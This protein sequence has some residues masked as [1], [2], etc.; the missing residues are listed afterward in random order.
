MRKLQFWFAVVIVAVLV[1]SPVH[2]L[3]QFWLT[4]DPAG[5]AAS[6]QAISVAP[7]KPVTLYCF[8]STDTTGNTFETM[9]G[10]DVSDATTYGSGKDT[11]NGASKKLTL[12][13][14]QAAIASSID[15]TFFNAFPAAGFTN[16]QVVLDASGVQASNA[17][18]GG[19]PYG[20]IARGA[21]TGAITY[22]LS[23]KLFSFAL[24]NNMPD[25]Q[26]QN[27]VVS[28]TYAGSN[29]YSSAWKYGTTM[30]ENEYTLT[31]NSVTSKPVI[32]ASNRSAASKVAGTAQA[33]YI[34][35]LYGKVSNRDTNGFQINDGSGTTITV[36]APGN[37]VAEGNYVTVKGTL[38]A[39]NKTLTSQSIHI[40]N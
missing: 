16:A 34:W 13:S 31:I 29:S 20:F 14:N 26:S 3:T 22:P 24:N 40:A 9:I 38:D 17:G 4:T 27:V 12:A 2:A 36:V 8:M 15:G 33:T 39:T 18:L 5:T 37:S 10:Y 6:G 19:R 32:A 21:R 35:L 28:T 1:C 11:N 30:A 7:N 25:G 23:V